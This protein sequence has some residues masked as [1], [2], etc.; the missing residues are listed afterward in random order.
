MRENLHFIVRPIY[1]RTFSLIRKRIDQV[2]ACNRA[3]PYIQ[4]QEARDLESKGKRERRA[5]LF[6][7]ACEITHICGSKDRQGQRIEQPCEQP[8]ST[9]YTRAKRGGA[10]ITGFR[11]VRLSKRLNYQDLRSSFRLSLSLSLLLDPSSTAGT[12][13]RRTIPRRSFLNWVIVDLFRNRVTA[14]KRI[15]TDTP[16]R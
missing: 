10:G 9:R 8:P 7:P 12:Y 15:T 3:C 11:D 2:D 6:L 4:D 16:I 13:T 14:S 1:D 5:E